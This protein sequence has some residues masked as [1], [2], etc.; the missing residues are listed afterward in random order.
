MMV[1]D[2]KILIRSG[3]VTPTAGAFD[4]G[5]PGFD[6]TAGTLWVKNAAGAMVQ[7]GSGGGGGAP[8]AHAASHAAAGADA[9]TLT[10]AQITD[11]AAAVASA[12]PAPIHPFLL[13]GG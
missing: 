2:N 11:F 10:A 1:R 7:I 3:T 9:V 5:E 4:I 13:M 6:K 8:S 12:A